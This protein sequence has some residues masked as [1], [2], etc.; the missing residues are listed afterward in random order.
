LKLCVE[1]VAVALYV[2]TPET[3][4]AVARNVVPS[5]NC[6]FPVGELAVEAPAVCAFPRKPAD[7]PV[8]ATDEAPATVAVKLYA[9]PA[10]GFT[11]ELTIVVAVAPLPTVICAETGE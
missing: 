2:A 4:A 3:S 10:A 7:G 5:M 8:V 11:G 6:T 9:A 1:L